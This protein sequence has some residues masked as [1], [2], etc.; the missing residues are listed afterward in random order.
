MPWVQAGS[1]NR[2]NGD[3]IFRSMPWIFS[4][5]APESIRIHVSSSVRIPVTSNMISEDVTPMIVR[6]SKTETW[7]WRRGV[8]ETRNSCILTGHVGLREYISSDGSGPSNDGAESEELE[9]APRMSG[10]V[11]DA[12]SSR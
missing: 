6:S 1:L 2:A 10:R 11:D 8:L 5:S 7:T 12:Y 9:S 3:A 4:M